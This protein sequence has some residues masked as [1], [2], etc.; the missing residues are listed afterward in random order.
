MVI[1]AVY[2]SGGYLFDGHEKPVFDSRITKFIFKSS[3]D[4][5]FVMLVEDYR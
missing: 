3:G 4:L 2:Y 1:A 5:N